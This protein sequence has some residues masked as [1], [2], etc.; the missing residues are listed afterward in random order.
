MDVI[1]HAVAGAATGAAFGR[2]LLGAVVAVV[3]DSALWLRPRLARPPAL[4]RA[5][6]GG[7]APLL[8]SAVCL[9]LFGS[10]VALVVL[11]AWISHIVLDIPTHGPDWSPRLFWPDERPVFTQFE[12][13][14]WFNLSWWCGLSLTIM[15][16]SLCLA[17]A[18]LR[19]IT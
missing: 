18:L 1:S 11:W 7:L 4:Y 8:V 19:H 9:P 16:S 17:L 15:W 6:H 5:A 12:E 2:P 13:W 14:E 3:P 10:Q